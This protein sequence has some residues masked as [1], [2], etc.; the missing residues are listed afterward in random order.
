MSE[1]G[2]DQWFECR[3]GHD[4]WGRFGAAGLL[5]YRGE[6]VL[7]QL[8][9]SR[10]HHGD[11]WG[12]PGGARKR[13]E[14]ALAAALREGREEAGLAV[15]LLRPRWWFIAD[16]CPWT[17]TTIA[18]QAPGADDS[19]AGDSAAGGLFAGG[20]FAGE[21]NWETA[22]LAWAP[23]DQASGAD[24][25]PGLAQAWPALAP[26]VGERLTLIVDAANVVGS[27][28]DGWWRD[29]AGAAKRL[30]GELGVLAAVGLANTW[31][32]APNGWYPEIVMVVEGQARGIG[33][34]EGVR[35]VDAP[36]EG[37]DEIVAQAGRAVATGRGPVLVATADRGLIA[38]LPRG[39][40]RPCQVLAPAR[41]RS[42]L[43]GG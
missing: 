35:V 38:R 33:P 1:D 4:H 14:K 34:G 9:G 2:S 13:G 39:G 23:R 32:E 8:R 17:Y 26:L 3:C 40:H 21:A 19:A 12:L 10:T 22:E 16:H 41:L 7:L 15:E 27:R 28:P 5:V 6:E 29:R 37:D 36:G 43:T 11:T 24:L 20:L 25:H 31:T 42:L 18:V 30:R